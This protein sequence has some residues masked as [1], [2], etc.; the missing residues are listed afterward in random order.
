MKPS[1]AR[2]RGPRGHPWSLIQLQEAAVTEDAPRAAQKK[3]KSE[4]RAPFC[5]PPSPADNR[6]RCFSLIPPPSSTPRSRVAPL[7]SAPPGP[8]APQ[9]G[10]AA[11]PRPSGVLEAFSEKA[12]GLLVAFVLLLWRIKG[13]QQRP[14]PDPHCSQPFDVCGSEA[15]SSPTPRLQTGTKPGFLQLKKQN[16]H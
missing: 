14:Q 16:K 1:S 12:F 6:M 7:S 15:T 4:T 2:V 10:R 8:P 9:T 11:A 3:L 13:A 5:P